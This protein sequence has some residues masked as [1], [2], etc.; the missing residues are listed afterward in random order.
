MKRIGIIAAVILVLVIAGILVINGRKIDTD[1]T[2]EHTKVGVILNGVKNDRSWS[3]SHY[4]G[5][6]QCAAK[7]NLDVEYREKVPNDETSID[8][9]DELIDNGCNMRL[10]FLR[11]MGT[12]GGQ[13][14]SGSVFSACVRNE[15]E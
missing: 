7:L 10:V 4:E 3:Q 8:V 6:E 5:M 13:G 11:G 15:T 1:V 14:T 12:G 2:R 9:M